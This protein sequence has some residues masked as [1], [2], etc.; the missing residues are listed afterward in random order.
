MEP[1][2]TAI[3]QR[4]ANTT[5]IQHLR[6][7]DSVEEHGRVYLALSSAVSRLHSFLKA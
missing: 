7:L 6:E 1:T 3:R 4:L 2:P 5:C